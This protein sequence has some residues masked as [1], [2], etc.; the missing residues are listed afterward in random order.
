MDDIPNI[1]I[2]TAIKQIQLSPTPKLFR[3]AM[4]YL[5]KLHLQMQNMATMHP[6]TPVVCLNF[7][8]IRKRKE[9]NR[10][11]VLKK[12]GLKDTE[13]TLLFQNLKARLK[14]DLTLPITHLAVKYNCSNIKQMA[15]S[16]YDTFKS[17]FESKLSKDQLQ[18]VRWGDEYPV[19]ALYLTARKQKMKL[20][21]TTILKDCNIPRTSLETAKDE[22]IALCGD[23]FGSEV[24]ISLS[25]KKSNDSE[26]INNKT[27]SINIFSSTNTTDEQNNKNNNEL[28]QNK[29][30]NNETTLT[31]YQ[32]K[33]NHVQVQ[34][35]S[36]LKDSSENVIPNVTSALQEMKQNREAFREKIKNKQQKEKESSQKKGLLKQQ[37]TN[38]VSKLKQVTMHN[39]GLI[40]NKKKT[41]SSLDIDE[42]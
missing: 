21:L 2:K 23:L 6:A 39:F 28:L 17:R 37:K 4:Q 18:Y 8:Y 16:N 32:S 20:D 36:K 25:N 34:N 19:A 11:E 41:M 12:I 38:K 15:K 42:P 40:Q 9:F 27:N 13:Y 3:K 14:L 35:Q 26:N 29:E 7:A 24:T 31:E 5:R 30:K 10:E 22:I 1:Q 33:E